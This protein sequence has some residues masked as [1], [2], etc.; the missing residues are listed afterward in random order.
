[1]DT[2]VIEVLIK[3]KKNN[4]FVL[5]QNVCLFLALLSFVFMVIFSPLCIFGIAIFVGLRYIFFYLSD[6][7]YEYSYFDRELVVDAIY[8]KS[9]RR[10]VASFQLEQ[11]EMAAPE[12]SFKLDIYKN[13]QCKTIDY[14]SGDKDSNK[15]I[16]YL[17][18]NKK[19]VLEHDEQ[20]VKTMRMQAPSKVSEA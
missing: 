1:M 4:L 16:M 12:K 13:R 9:R 20:M 6:I 19:L 11:V 7:E 8:A 3:R 17:N 5:L 15:F 10:R 2:G 18:D 14:S